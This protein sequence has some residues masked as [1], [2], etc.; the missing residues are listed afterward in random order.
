ML[1]INASLTNFSDLSFIFRFLPIFLIIYYIVPY[2]FRNAV[3]ALGS[4]FFYA[5]S[6]LRSM[7][8]FA[9]SIVVNYLFSLMCVKHK[10]IALF[11]ILLL[12]SAV[13]MFFK[14]MSGYGTGFMLPV[15]I[16]FFTF[17]MVSFQIDCYKGIIKKSP[18]FMN[19]V[20]YFSMFPQVISGPIMRYEQFEKNNILSGDRDRFLDDI[21]PA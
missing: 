3:L 21:D 9:V 15:G 4:L 13:L 18:G 6:D 1:P 5:V 14:L 11:L 8:V 20:S 19:T 17:K 7:A 10:K 2:R 16:S 12:D